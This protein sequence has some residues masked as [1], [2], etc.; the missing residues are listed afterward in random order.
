MTGIPDDA[1]PNAADT[2]NKHERHRGGSTL[3]PAA[4]K[5]H[6]KPTWGNGTKTRVPKRTAEAGSG[7]PNSDPEATSLKARRRPQS[8]HPVDDGGHPRTPAEPE[9]GPAEVIPDVV[10]SGTKV[11]SA[12][13]DAVVSPAASTNAPDVPLAAP[14]L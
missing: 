11:I 13:G 2:Q 7:V 9:T 5:E 14:G 8:S 10:A 4:S 1:L 6:S 3:K 12:V